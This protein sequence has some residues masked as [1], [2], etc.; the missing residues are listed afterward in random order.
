[1][2]TIIFFMAVIV[3]VSFAAF[4]IITKE[5]HSK[6]RSIIKIAS[7]IGFVLLTVLHIIDWSLSY[8]ALASLLI[9]LAITGAK[10]LTQKKKE[11]REYN[12]ARV[13][14]RSIGMMVLIF[15]V[16][17]PAIIFPQNKA[18][19]PTT[20]EYQILT[21]TYTYTDKNRVE[22]YT[23]TGK[24]RKLNVKFWYPDNLD[25][26]VPLIVFSHGGLGIKS[27]NESLYNE[28]ASHGYVVCSIDHTYQSF[29][30]TDQDGNMTL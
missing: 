11:K 22:S 3:E 17:L 13:V 20:G 16:T 23:D 27:S 25:E 6:E 9:L 24:S 26:S 29:Y 19:I 18:V 12:T 4:C 8:Y 15:A 28:L 7:F 2:G 30:S 21:Q 14:L 10:S 1:M 5:N